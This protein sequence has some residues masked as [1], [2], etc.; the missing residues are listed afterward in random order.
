MPK[1]WKPKDPL[2]PR[3][4]E[5]LEV[6]GRKHVKKTTVKQRLHR[7]FGRGAK[8]CVFCG[9]TEGLISAYGL[10]ICRRCFRELAPKL[11]FKKYD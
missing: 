9:N 6:F 3:L 5:L 11:G 1:L 8:R 10:Y 4:L 7:K 2:K